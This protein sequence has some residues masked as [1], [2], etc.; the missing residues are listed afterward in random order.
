MREFG[1]VTLGV[2]DGDIRTDCV[3]DMD[4]L[5]GYERG[6]GVSLVRISGLKE[7]TS[8]TTEVMQSPADMAD[9]SFT[10]YYHLVRGVRHSPSTYKNN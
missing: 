2:K 9:V 1:E 5:K 7:N 4:D 6:K 3:E 8:W 10:V